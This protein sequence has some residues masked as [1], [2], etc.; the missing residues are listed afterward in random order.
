MSCKT[1]LSLRGGLLGNGGPLPPDGLSRLPLVLGLHGTAGMVELLR[2][3]GQCDSCWFT[4][5]VHSS[6]EW[7]LGLV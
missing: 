5:R 3:C 4:L 6:P 1:D 7:F 2:E